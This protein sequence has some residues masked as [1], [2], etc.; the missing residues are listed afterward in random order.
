MKAV[1]VVTP[2]QPDKVDAWKK[3]GE[4]MSSGKQPGFAELLKKGG[5]TRVRAWLSHTPAGDLAVIVH[6][7]PDPERWL[8]TAME[9]TEPAAEWFRAQIKEIHGM[10]AKD[11]PPPLP[12][13]IFDYQLD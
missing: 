1:T 11:G 13:L 12:E 4:E 7:G 8:P 3:F 2:L 9:S 6:E 10:D 5:V